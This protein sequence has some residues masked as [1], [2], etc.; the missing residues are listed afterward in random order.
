[1]RHPVFVSL[2]V[3]GA[4]SLSACARSGNDEVQR[5]MA[6]LD[7]INS[8]GLNEVM[9]TVGDPA[10]SVSYFARALAAN[11]GRIDL[12]R[13]LA[14]SQVRA[15][16]ITGKPV[17]SPRRRTWRFRPSFKVTSSQVLSPSKRRRRTSAGCVSRPS[18]TMR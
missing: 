15:S 18:I 10:E 6:D 16:R 3:V 17:T 8:Q 14:T 7:A 1:M 13:G 4:I 11:P 5:A 9:M 2:I 12:M